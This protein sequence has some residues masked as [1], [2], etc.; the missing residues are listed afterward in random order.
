MEYDNKL[1]YLQICQ[2][3]IIM[4]FVEKISFNEWV[5][6]KAGEFIIKMVREKANI[7]GARKYHKLVNK[8][9]LIG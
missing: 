9:Y 1:C 4:F 5:F 8:L 3:Q 2:L 7:H 6:E